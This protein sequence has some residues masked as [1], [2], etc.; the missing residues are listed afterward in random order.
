MGSL[1]PRL[2]KRVREQPVSRQGGTQAG[3]P[4]CSAAPPLVCPGDCPGDCPSCRCTGRDTPRTME[5][6]GHQSEDFCRSGKDQW[7]RSMQS[8]PQ[9]RLLRL[10]GLSV[11]AQCSRGAA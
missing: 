8:P 1:D 7:R 4:G 10:R 3:M 5:A 9:T 11:L 6:A 2:H